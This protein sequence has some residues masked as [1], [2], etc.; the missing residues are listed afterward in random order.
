[1]VAGTVVAAAGATGVGATVAGATMVGIMV[2]AM[3]AGMAMEAAVITIGMGATIIRA[4][5]NPDM[6]IQATLTT[7]MV[8]V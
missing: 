7:T 8:K 6:L 1:M 5:G 3:G 4:A 2:G